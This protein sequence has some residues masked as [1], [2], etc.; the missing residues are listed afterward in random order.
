[1][2]EQ[3]RAILSNIAPDLPSY[4]LAKGG[5]VQ[6]APLSQEEYENLIANGYQP[7]GDVDY[8][9]LDKR[10]LGALNKLLGNLGNRAIL[11]FPLAVSAIL[12]HE[13]GREGS[14]LYVALQEAQNSKALSETKEE[15]KQRRKKE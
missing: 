2:K 6:V 9:K 4:F 11:L 8:S 5:R 7:L 3:F 13:A 1:M 10:V 15:K 12:A 14:E